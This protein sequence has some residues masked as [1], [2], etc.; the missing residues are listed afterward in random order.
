MKSIVYILQIFDRFI[1]GDF[2]WTIIGAILFGVGLFVAK[3]IEPYII[4]RYAKYSR[5]LCPV[6][7]GV[8]I[9]LIVWFGHEWIDPYFH[10][11]ELWYTSPLNG[12]HMHII[13]K[14]K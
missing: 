13:T 3:L 14:C 11:M 6:I 9:A 2:K 4:K 10:A 7:A 1:L 5:W 12:E 8:I